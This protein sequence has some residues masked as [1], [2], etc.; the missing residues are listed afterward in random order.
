MSTSKK[1]PLIIH[2]GHLARGIYD[3]HLFSPKILGSYFNTESLKLQVYT[4]ILF[5]YFVVSDFLR[6]IVLS[7]DYHPFFLQTCKNQKKT[8]W[9]FI[10]QKFEAFGY[11]KAVHQ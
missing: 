10:F 2:S 5:A 9:V 7:F 1:C 4:C 6:E 8:A 3:F 11:T